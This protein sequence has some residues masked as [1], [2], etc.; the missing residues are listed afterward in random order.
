[1][2]KAVERNRSTWDQN[3]ERKNVSKHCLEP[4]KHDP[5]G[6]MQ[7]FITVDETWIRYYTPD[8]NQIKTMGF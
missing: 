4:F 6:F 5:K 8:E 2:K 1:M 7:C 3:L